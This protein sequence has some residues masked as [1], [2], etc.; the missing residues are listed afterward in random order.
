MRQRV[1]L[2]L[3]LFCLAILT[4]SG[5]SSSISPQTSVSPTE[6]AKQLVTL[7]SQMQEAVLAGDKERYLEYVVSDLCSQS[8]INTELMAG[9]KRLQQ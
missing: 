4:L 2:S 3:L 5:C 7:V 8:N 9:L 6:P 1:M